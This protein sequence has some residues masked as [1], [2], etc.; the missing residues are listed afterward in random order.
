[1]R[2]SRIYTPLDLAVGKTVELEGQAVHYLS[3][4]LRLSEGDVVTLFNGNGEEYSGVVREIHPK[5]ALVSL[6]DKRDPKTESPLKITLAQ[7]ISRGDRMDYTVQKAAELGVHAIQPLF[8]ER[9]AV[10]LDDKRRVKRLAHWQGVVTSACEQSG[11]VLV[12]QVLEPLSL[13]DWLASDG[14][15][16]KLVLDPDAGTSL[17]TCTVDH[18]SISLLVGPEGGFSHREI[19]VVTAQGVTGVSMGPR[20]LR[21]ESA[22]PAAIALLQALAGDY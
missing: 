13:A 5:R 9:V 18:H 3:R 22:G 6:S 10:R 17:S 16:Q 12:P 14:H 8:T 20:I 1:M 7:A 11:R 2:L 4:V 19:D 15:V 21:T